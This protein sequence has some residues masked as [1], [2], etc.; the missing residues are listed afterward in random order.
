MGRVFRGQKH[1]LK[2]LS[3]GMK[4]IHFLFVVSHIQH[5]SQKKP[6]LNALVCIYKDLPKHHSCDQN[7]LFCFVMRVLTLQSRN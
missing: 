2:Q 3:A 5:I 6:N 4:L 1:V 7:E